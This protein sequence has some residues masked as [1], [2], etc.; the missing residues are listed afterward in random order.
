M[1][2]LVWAEIAEIDGDTSFPGALGLSPVGKEPSGVERSLLVRSNG[3]W[4]VDK[5]SQGA[6]LHDLMSQEIPSREAWART[7]AQID[8]FY[9]T[10]SDDVIRTYNRLVYAL[11]VRG[12][13]RKKQPGYVYVISD[14]TGACKIGLSKSPRARFKA[15]ALQRGRKITVEVMLETDEMGQL[16]NA[17]HSRFW[18]KHLEG[19]WFSLDEADLAYIASLSGRVA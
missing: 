2:D 16:E 15:L 7:R 12:H 9:A 19:E 3:A 14:G 8:E 18:D 17:L 13:S 11:L 1:N 6:Y 10:T 5:G 4:F